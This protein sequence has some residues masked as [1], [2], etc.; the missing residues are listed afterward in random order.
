VLDERRELR[1]FNYFAG[2]DPGLAVELRDYLA[3]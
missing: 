2:D 3:G 1:L